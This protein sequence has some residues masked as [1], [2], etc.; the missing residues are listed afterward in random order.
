MVGDDAHGHVAL[1]ILAVALARERGDAA[2]GGL[3]DVGVVVGFLALE[4]HAEALEAHAR[5]DVARRQLLERAVGLA[6]ELHEDQ[7]PDLDDLGMARVDHL[8]AGLR[9]DLRLVAQ[10]EVDLRA[11][12]A[13]TRLAH[14]PEVVVLVAANDMVGGQELQPVVVG[15]LVEGHAVLLRTLE[16]GGVHAI[17]RELVDVVQ[18]L[19]GPLDGLALEVVAVGPVAQHLEHGV[20]VG[21]V[22]HL[23]QVV[24]LARDAQTL[25]RVGARGYLRGALPRKISLNW[26]MPALVNMSVGSPLTTIGAEGTIACSF[27]AKKSRK[28]RRISFDSIIYRFILFFR[29]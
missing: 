11:G 8:A 20:V 27:D 19:P 13:G 1:L 4:D 21:V 28:A 24:V 12:A 17:G 16:D 6:V 26:F 10:V 2:D 22:A 3:E 25:L 14:L 7:V 18:Q 15:L 29:W 5:V 23:L 9:G